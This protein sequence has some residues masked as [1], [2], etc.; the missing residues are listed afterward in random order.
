[1]V[2]EDL[3]NSLAHKAHVAVAK[4]APVQHH[5]I[6]TEKLNKLPR[7]WRGMAHSINYNEPTH[8]TAAV[9]GL[10]IVHLLPGKN[11]VI[12]IANQCSSKG[13]RTKASH[14]AAPTIIAANKDNQ[15]NT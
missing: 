1:M 3:L 9:T 10:T 15:D 12:T 4:C 5:K 8:V 7:K 14:G 11:P 2:V 13:A 6:L